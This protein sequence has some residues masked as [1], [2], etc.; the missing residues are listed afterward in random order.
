MKNSYQK[1]VNFIQLKI[2]NLGV[3]TVLGLNEICSDL[4]I[5]S[6][7]HHEGGCESMTFLL[8]REYKIKLIGDKITKTNLNEGFHLYIE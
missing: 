1:R 7:N 4:Y 8:M 5:K 6:K 3:E 2:Y